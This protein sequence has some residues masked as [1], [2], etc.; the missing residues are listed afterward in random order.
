MK[1]LLTLSLFVALLSFVSCDK[2]KTCN[3][4][5][6]LKWNVEGMEPT[7]SE[8]TTT[9]DKGECSDGNASQLMNAGGQQYTAE[10]TC[11]EA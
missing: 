1:K 3:C 11:V 9:I 8:R 4:T 10:I 7:V 6:V 5:T 2:S